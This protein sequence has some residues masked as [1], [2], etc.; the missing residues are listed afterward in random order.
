MKNRRFG[1]PGVTAV[2]RRIPFQIPFGTNSL[3]PSLPGPPWPMP[4]K[5]ADPVLPRLPSGIS[6]MHQMRT[7]ELQP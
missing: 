5:V 2:D 7:V 1:R 6:D 4:G 3:R